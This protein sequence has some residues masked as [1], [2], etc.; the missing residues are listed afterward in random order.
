MKSH[1]SWWSAARP[2]QSPRALSCAA[3]AG[4]H[5]AP[6]T[7]PPEKQAGC[8]TSV[9]S[10]VAISLRRPRGL[11]VPGLTWRPECAPCA[12]ELP[13]VAS[14]PPAALCLGRAAPGSQSRCAAAQWGP[15]SRLQAAV[16]GLP[17][18]SRKSVKLIS[19]YSLS[20]NALL[21][22]P[23]SWS[24]FL[25]RSLQKTRKER[26]KARVPGAVRNVTLSLYLHCSFY[27]TGGSQSQERRDCILSLWLLRSFIIA[28][29]EYIFMDFL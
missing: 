28:H 7:A 20:L 22:P 10:L 11:H 18:G 4:A 23:P 24:H 8:K 17:R 15:S 25:F 9:C 27:S 26:K 19:V 5:F 16:G 1:R 14:V 21:P 3:A 12:A 2:F 13:A 29:T 6:L